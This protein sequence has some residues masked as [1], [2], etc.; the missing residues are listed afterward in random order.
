MHAL[1]ELI[2]RLTVHAASAAALCELG[3]LWSVRGPCGNRHSGTWNNIVEHALHTLSVLQ[4]NIVSRK[5]D[6]AVRAGPC[7]LST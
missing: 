1:Y 5:I 2:C 4:N 6:P 7:P 3:I